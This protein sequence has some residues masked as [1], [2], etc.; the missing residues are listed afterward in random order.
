MVKRLTW[1]LSGAAAG[2]VGASVARKKVKAAAADLA[3]SNL[4]HKAADRA[5]DAVLDVKQA[6][7]VK[8]VELRARLT[9]NAGHAGTLADELE[10]GATVLVEGRPVEPGQVIVLRPLREHKE[11]G[12]HSRRA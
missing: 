4:A 12:R 3:P 10:E 11:A 6:L 2:V 5:R 9:G 7:K 1:F 8:Q